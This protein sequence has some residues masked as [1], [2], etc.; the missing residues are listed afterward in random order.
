MAIDSVAVTQLPRRGEKRASNISRGNPRGRP[1]RTTA[2]ALKAQINCPTK[3]C[4]TLLVHKPTCPETELSHEITKV[5]KRS[6][7]TTGWP[8][9][10]PSRIGHNKC[11]DAAAAG[12]MKA[13]NLSASNQPAHLWKSQCTL[14]YVQA[15]AALRCFL[16]R[17]DPSSRDIALLSAAILTCFECILRPR[18]TIGLYSHTRG[19][20]AILLASSGKEEL[21]EVSRA[22]LY[23]NWPGTFQLPLAFGVAS[24]FE[25]VRWLEVKTHRQSKYPPGLAK[26]AKIYKDL[27]IRL[28]RLVA[29]TRKLRDQGPDKETVRQATELSTELLGFSSRIAENQLLHRVGVKKT[30]DSGDAQ[31]VPFSFKFRRNGE[32]A[33]AICYWQTRILVHRLCLKLKEQ[34][35]DQHQK[36]E[37]SWLVAE[38]T[39][40]ATNIMMSWEFAYPIRCVGLWALRLGMVALWTVTQDVQMWSK[41]VCVATLRRWILKRYG[42]LHRGDTTFNEDDM[43]EAADLLAGGSLR[44]FLTRLR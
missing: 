31:V 30:A 20:S 39:R 21:T 1:K 24:P 10:I 8:S 11:M 18:G 6:H 36:V 32:F 27:F 38:N 3:Y 5:F 33:V 23:Y 42:D 25:E 15:M 17:S 12:L 29:V 26:L 28:P 41:D 19:I 22:M 9:F 44:G 13:L 35:V 16:N 2:Y 4:T 14:N 43:D 40:L 37:R 7:L 34:G